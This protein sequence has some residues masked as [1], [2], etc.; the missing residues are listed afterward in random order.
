MATTSFA[1]TIQ[2]KIFISQ[3]IEHP[4]LNITT[5]GILDALAENGFKDNIEIKVENAQG[6]GVIAA[7]IAAK[8]VNRNPDVVVGVGTVSAQSFLKYALKDQVKL[9]F[10]TV[11]DPASAGLIANNVTG[12]SNFID[13][14]PQLQ[15]F[16]K[17][18]PSLKRLG[19]IYNAG[20]SNSIAIVKK[21][22]LVC[23]KLGITLVKQ[24]ANNTSDVSLAATKLVN[25]VDGLFIS[26]DNNALSAIGTI[27]M[28]ATKAK[29]PV[30]VSDTDEVKLGAL[31]AM[32][33]NQYQVG[34]QSGRMIADILNGKPINQ[35]PIEFPRT[36]DLFINLDSARSLDI[37]IPSELK[38]RAFK[39]IG[40]Q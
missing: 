21:L 38:Q 16:Q 22:E 8:F 28:I 1:N 37:V 14:E 35:I 18:Q 31:A 39:I 33:P 32:G 34:M 27:I 20:E 13:L 25:Q 30:Y 7:Q 26:N 9:V 36:Q 11:S 19:V 6:S 12:V 4:A 40:E 3:V 23:P 24:I 29:I 17:I 15:L 5:K 2:K 10:S